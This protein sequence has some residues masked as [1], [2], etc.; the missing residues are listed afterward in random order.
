MPPFTHLR[1][2]EEGEPMA[3]VPVSLRQPEPNTAPE[4]HR[5]PPCATI[6]QER[7]KRAPFMKA[8]SGSMR[9]V[10]R[11]QE[12][13]D[14]RTRQHPSFLCPPPHGQRPTANLGHIH[15]PHSPRQSPGIYSAAHASSAGDSMPAPCAAPLNEPEKASSLLIE[16]PIAVPGMTVRTCVGVS[17]VTSGRLQIHSA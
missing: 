3:Y 9:I 2:G 4:A 12:K 8:F 1:P 10:R 16:P 6:C 15:G 11:P 5:R 14:N 17:G 7:S 13:P